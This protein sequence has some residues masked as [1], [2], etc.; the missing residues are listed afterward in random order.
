MEN[1]T[2]LSNRLDE[3]N[4]IVENALG[5]NAKKTPWFLRFAPKAK[6]IVSFVQNLLS[7]LTQKEGVRGGQL[8]AFFQSAAAVVV[9][10]GLLVGSTGE[11]HGQAVS[12]C[13]PPLFDVCFHKKTGGWTS[14]GYA[15]LA[16]RFDGD[17]EKLYEIVWKGYKR[18]WSSEERRFVFTWDDVSDLGVSGGEPDL[19]YDF[20][21]SSNFEELNG[22]PLSYGCDSLRRPLGLGQYG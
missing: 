18:L 4:G 7:P 12:Y 2:V 22:W 19:D 11:V 5:M 17:S 10:I 8:S 15:E 9:G 1:I 20:W 16:I 21:W 6:G 3:S 13:D 14:S